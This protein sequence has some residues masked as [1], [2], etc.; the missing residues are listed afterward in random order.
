M[1]SLLIFAVWMACG[2]AGSGFMFSAQQWR[3]PRIAQETLRADMG[4]A[5]FLALFGP[6]TLLIGYFFSGFAKY[7]CWRRYKSGGV[8]STQA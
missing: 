8:K 4:F 1:E 2:L 7:G 5:V 6:V 3:F